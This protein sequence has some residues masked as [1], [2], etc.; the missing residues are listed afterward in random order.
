ME[1]QHLKQQDICI[2][3]Q[4]QITK[5]VPK[6]ISKSNEKLTEKLEK[7]KKEINDQNQIWKNESNIKN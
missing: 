5:E 2:K 7:M 6:L 3:L 1:K 4:E